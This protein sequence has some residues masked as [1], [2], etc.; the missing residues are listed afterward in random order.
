MFVPEKISS[1]V[2]K[3]I[4]LFLS[5][6]EATPFHGSPTVWRFS[7]QV[8][9][10]CQS[11]WRS[12]M[13]QCYSQLYW[14]SKILE[15]RLPN[16]GYTPLPGGRV[17]EEPCGHQDWV[18]RYRPF[19]HSY[20]VLQSFAGYL[21]EARSMVELL[22]RLSPPKFILNLVT[23]APNLIKTLH[24]LFIGPQLQTKY[25]PISIDK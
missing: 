17:Q 5:L 23:A 4:V 9:V 13:P 12:T 18:E 6:R 3:I 11:Y 22:W 7:D 15:P 19:D 20:K 1:S 10:L 14:A 21:S 16:H 24:N 2:S 25:F 8:V